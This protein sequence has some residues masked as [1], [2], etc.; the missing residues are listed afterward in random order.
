MIRDLHDFIPKWQKEMESANKKVIKLEEKIITIDEE[1]RDFQRRYKE[2]LDN[3]ISKA[4][5]G[6]LLSAII[7]RLNPKKN[8]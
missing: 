3:D 8:G 6:Q 2:K 4:T 1:R 5:M 7:G